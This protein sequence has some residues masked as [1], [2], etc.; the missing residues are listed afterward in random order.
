MKRMR[1]WDSVS[2]IL[3]LFGFGLYG[4]SC[5]YGVWAL[6]YVALGCIVL[7]AVIAVRTQRCPFCHRYLGMMFSPTKRRTARTAA[8]TCVRTEMF[9]STVIFRYAGHITV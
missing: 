2:T 6:V 3:V 1:F 5:C 4:S 8:V 9:D 7:G